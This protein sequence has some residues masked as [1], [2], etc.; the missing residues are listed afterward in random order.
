MRNTLLVVVAL[1]L[2]GCGDASPSPSTEAQHKKPAPVA[3]VGG[4]D[5]VASGVEHGEVHGEVAGLVGSVDHAGAE[6]H[7]RALGGDLRG[8]NEKARGSDTHGFGRDQPDMAVD[9]LAG[10]PTGVGLGGGVGAN[11]ER[12][13]P[14]VAAFE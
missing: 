13:G 5:L 3:P 1:A 4:A 11:R 10:I 7:D 14:V 6:A 2:V 12:V 8:G 9:A